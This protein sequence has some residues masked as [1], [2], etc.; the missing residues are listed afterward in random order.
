MLGYISKKEVRIIRESTHLSKRLG[1]GCAER[2]HVGKKQ[3]ATKAKCYMW[4]DAMVAAFSIVGAL[5]AFCTTIPSVLGMLT[6]LHVR[7]PAPLRIF[8]RY[9]F[10]LM[11]VLC[12]AKIRE[13]KA[14]FELHLECIQPVKCFFKL[15]HP[16]QVFRIFEA[17]RLF[18]VDVFFELGIEESCPNV[19]LVELKVEFSYDSEEDVNCVI[20]GDCCKCFRVVDTFDLHHELSGDAHAWLKLSGIAVHEPSGFGISSIGGG[21]NEAGTMSICGGAWSSSPT[22]MC[23]SATAVGVDAGG[24]PARDGLLGG[25]IPEDV[26]SVADMA[27]EEAMPGDK[28][29]LAVCVLWDMRISETAKRAEVA[30]VWLPTIENFKGSV[31]NEIGGRENHCLV[32]LPPKLEVKLYTLGA[33][34]QQAKEYL[35]PIHGFIDQVHRLLDNVIQLS[36]TIDSITTISL[37]LITPHTMFAEHKMLSI[38]GLHIVMLWYC[39]PTTMWVIEITDLLTVRY[40]ASIMQMSSL[41]ELVWL[42]ILPYGWSSYG[43]AGMST[44]ISSPPGTP[45]PSI[46]NTLMDWACWHVLGTRMIDMNITSIKAEGRNEEEDNCTEQQGSSTKS[47]DE[48]EG[49]YDSEGS[50]CDGD[51]LNLRLS[52]GGMPCAKI[53]VS[54]RHLTHLHSMIMSLVTFGNYE[55]PNAG[56]EHLLYVYDPQLSSLAFLSFHHWQ[57]VPTITINFVGYL[58]LGPQPTL[59]PLYG[60]P[61]SHD[62]NSDDICPPLNLP[63]VQGKTGIDMKVH[64]VYNHDGLA[65]ENKLTTIIH[66]AVY[67]MGYLCPILESDYMV[68]FALS[69]IGTMSQLDAL[70]QGLS[71]QDSPIPT[72]W[73]GSTVNTMS[74]GPSSVLSMKSADTQT[75]SKKKLAGGAM[76]IHTIM[77]GCP[78]WR[79]ALVYLP[80]QRIPIFFSP[81]TIPNVEDNVSIPSGPSALFHPDEHTVSLKKPSTVNTVRN[82][83]ACSVPSFI[84][85]GY[86]QPS[87]EI[88]KNAMNGLSHHHISKAH[89]RFTLMPAGNLL[90]NH[91][92]WN[93]YIFQFFKV[94]ESK[95][96]DLKKHCVHTE[97]DMLSEALSRIAES[98]GTKSDVSIFA[99]LQS[100]ILNENWISD[101]T[102]WLCPHANSDEKP[103]EG[104]PSYRAQGSQH[105]GTLPAIYVCTSPPILKVQ[106]LV[107]PW[108]LH[109][110]LGNIFR[111]CVEEVLKPKCFQGGHRA[112]DPSSR[113]SQASEGSQM[114]RQAFSYISHDHDIYVLDHQFDFMSGHENNPSCSDSLRKHR[115]HQI[116]LFFMVNILAAQCLPCA[117]IL[118][119]LLQV[120]SDLKNYRTLSSKIIQLS[121]LDH[122]MSSEEE[123][124]VHMG[125][126]LGKGASGLDW[127]NAE[128]KEGLKSGI[129][130]VRGDQ[131]P[132]FL[133]ARYEYD[134]E[135]PWKGL[136]H[137]EIL[138]FVSLFY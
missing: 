126:L 105:S 113:M 82:V 128:T 37:G 135:D 20:F 67:P 130:T 134:P 39:A 23:G 6:G 64:G 50:I 59:H 115:L 17:G 91:T 121:L 43:F 78:K 27:E 90:I 41:L 122:L 65:H 25:R 63:W 68:Q 57:G 19:H 49:M 72:F 32:S 120:Y 107:R 69:K 70:G 4:M 137:S 80:R 35:A 66:Y 31:T 112:A 117:I 79:K 15:S 29:I 3:E 95:S 136:L 104:A 132:V 13:V 108:I 110:C 26:S 89:Q 129:T 14:L 100:T 93:V 92:L 53:T 42:T 16:I 76:N 54:T 131:W 98:E 123:D 86:F 2:V 125:E 84:R 47:L 10:W 109:W 9:A 101:M 114:I 102:M 77:K 94:K 18:E 85:L 40:W 38:C 103:G 44:W 81:V 97:V 58:V 22:D 127:S 74:A 75:H 88:E 124:I 96:L 111:M 11:E 133:Y 51:L 83:G 116:P 106:I 21:G 99:S 48:S 12:G 118:L 36:R 8:S 46:E 7:I 87:K 71:V 30:D 119:S 1:K 52:D 56:Y 62:A 28:V 60:P 73:R 45:P 55:G 138:I 5:M 61:G 33:L 34:F 24:S